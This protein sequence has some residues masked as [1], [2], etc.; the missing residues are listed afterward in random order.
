[1][2][3][4]AQKEEMAGDEPNKLLTDPQTA[5]LLRICLAIKPY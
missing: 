1:M 5:W 3:V 2:T 4:L